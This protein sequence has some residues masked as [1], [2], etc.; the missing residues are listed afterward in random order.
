MFPSSYNIRERPLG[1]LP[2]IINIKK[3][4]IAAFDIILSIS[5]NL[6]LLLQLIPYYLPPISILY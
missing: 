1:T 5:F 6:G 4:Y 2:D 3:K